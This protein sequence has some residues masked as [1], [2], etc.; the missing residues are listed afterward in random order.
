MVV[1]HPGISCSS[2]ES[3]LSSY[4]SINYDAQGKVKPR[5]RGSKY[6]SSRRPSRDALVAA[7]VAAPIATDFV[8]PVTIPV[9]APVLSSAF[10]PVVASGQIDEAT[11]LMHRNLLIAVTALTQSNALILSKSD[12]SDQVA[13]RL[14]QC[15]DEKSL[16]IHSLC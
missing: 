5:R 1:N 14:D 16:A 8:A 4:E 12:T 13:C 10:T 2:S 15:F 3:S 6:R 7:P 9:S 11:A